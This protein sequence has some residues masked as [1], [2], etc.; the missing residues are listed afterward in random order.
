MGCCP[1]DFIK[2]CISGGALPTHFQ[3]KSHFEW[4]TAHSILS[5][6][7][8]QV[9]CHLIN[10]N[11]NRWFLWDSIHYQLTSSLSSAYARFTLN[12]LLAC[13]QFIPPGSLPAHPDSFPDSFQIFFCDFT[14]DDLNNIEKKTD[15][16]CFYFLPQSGIIQIENL[17]KRDEY[18]D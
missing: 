8:F 14:G 9:G 11:K 4:A 12:W 16:G 6:Y 3:Q 1:L 17:K 10:V 5:K 13:H 2:M 15:G 18:N 7:A